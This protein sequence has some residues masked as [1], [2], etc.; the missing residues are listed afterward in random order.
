MRNEP[1]LLPRFVTIGPALALAASLGACSPD[2]SPDTYAAG[3]VQ[4]ASKVDQGIVVG[5]RKIDVS[6]DTTLGVVTGAAAGGAVGSE[7]PGGGVSAALGTVSGGLIGGII[8][9]TAE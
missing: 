5:V 1:R 6:A 2:Y 3:A 4:Q 8:G 9:S 7:T